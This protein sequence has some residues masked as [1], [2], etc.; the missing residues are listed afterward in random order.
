MGSDAFGWG[1]KHT[2][3][4][5]NIHGHVVHIRCRYKYMILH[6]MTTSLHMK[7]AVFPAGGTHVSQGK[8]CLLANSVTNL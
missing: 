8:L 5:D 2:M 4:S 6:H 7:T 3:L 1:L